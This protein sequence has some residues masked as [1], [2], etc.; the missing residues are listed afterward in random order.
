MQETR[1]AD[2]MLENLINGVRTRRGESVLAETVRVSKSGVSRE[3]MAAEE[4]IRKVLAE[5]DGSD[6][7]ILDVWID[8]IQ[9]GSYHVCCAVGM[10]A[11]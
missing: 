10:D 1:L 7:D 6:L 5:R 8:G 4:Q 9:L 2:R 11:H 3:T